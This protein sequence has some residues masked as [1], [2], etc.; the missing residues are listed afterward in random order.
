MQ[1]DW[2]VSAIPVER[3]RRLWTSD[4]LAADPHLGRMWNLDTDWEN[5]MKFFLREQV[6]SRTASLF[7]STRLGVI[8][9][10]QPG[11]VLAA[12]LCRHLR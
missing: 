2:Y 6:R 8:T 10:R 7:I 12:P 9:L 4:I 5:G 3:A 11:A 1:A